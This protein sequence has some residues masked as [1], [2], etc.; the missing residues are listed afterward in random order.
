VIVEVS[1]ELGCAVLVTYEVRLLGMILCRES[2][3]DVEDVDVVEMVPF[4]L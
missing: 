1:V 4:Q 3:V 2:E